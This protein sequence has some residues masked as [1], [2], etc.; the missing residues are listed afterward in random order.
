MK[1]AYYL[2]R[3]P[4][5]SETFI[6]REILMLR[7][8]GYDV[9]VFS[10]LPPLQTN[11]MHTQ[12][13]P[14]LPFTHYSPLFSWNVLTALFHIFFRKPGRFLIAL[15]R[16]VWQTIP[17]PSTCL[18]ALILFPKMVYF[19]RQLEEMRVTRIHAHFVWIN[20][21]AAQVASDLIGIPCSLHAH[22]WDIFR[23]NKEC[24]QRQLE[25]AACVITVSEY[26]R[27]YLF[28]LN[29]KKQNSNIKVVHYGLDPGEFTP[30][31][32]N[33]DRKPVQIIS[34]GRLVEKKGF[35]YLVEGCSL[36]A[37]KGY[38]FRCSIIGEGQREEL[39]AQIDDLGLSKSVILLGAKNIS[40][41]VDQYR[42]SD[43]FALPCVVAGSGDRDGMPNV[44]LEAMAMQ[45]PVVT[46]PVA[47]NSELLQDGINGLLVPERDSSALA[48]A[49]ETLINNPALRKTLGI[50]ARRTI[51]RGYDI[52]A[53]AS[54]M[55][56][57]FRIR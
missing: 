36:L 4:R 28:S 57:L 5:L 35:K 56:E 53:T 1:I 18:L 48:Q 29:N 12:V 44:L 11:V 33:D 25:L 15:K 52:H 26:H 54:Q 22:A 10:L 9:Q 30:V 3:F 27:Q 14:V 17:E 23:R 42:S 40:E 49:I 8:M 13:Q 6:L 41:I 47:G 2:S 46:T 43:I 32:E 51:L 20:G 50:E 55:A 7:E 45:L 16:L 24:V 37:Q 39:Q 21:V 34:V 19:A 38:P 31:T